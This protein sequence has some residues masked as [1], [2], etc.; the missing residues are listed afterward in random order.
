M[1]CIIDANKHREDARHACP[2]CKQAFVTGVR[3]R[4]SD[5]CCQGT[6]A[7]YSLGTE[8][9]PCSSERRTLREGQLSAGS[10]LVSESLEIS[11][12]IFWLGPPCL[13]PPP[14]ATSAMCTKAR[15][16]MRRLSK[17]TKSVLKSSRLQGAHNFRGRMA[18][19]L[20]HSRNVNRPSSCNR[21]RS[22]RPAVSCPG[23]PGNSTGR[24]PQCA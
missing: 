5:G 24:Q 2:T 12:A 1:S 19:Q 21:S 13:W 7:H 15:E 6:T 8:L 22:S 23:V 9:R 10:W 14:V 18:A 20:R 17:C 4:T 3:R 11:A 16:S